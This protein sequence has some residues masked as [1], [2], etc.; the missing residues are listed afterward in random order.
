[1]DLAA[2]NSREPTRLDDR[3]APV[4]SFP[5][6]ELSIIVPTFN[7]HDNVAELLRRLRLC[8]PHGSW[9]VIFVD[10][11]S[12]DGT[13]ERVR[14]LAAEDSRVRCIQRVGRRGLASA[15]VEGMLSTSA[16]YLAVIDADLQHD[17]RLLPRMLEALRQEE[18][19]IV[20]GSR[21]AAGGDL[22]DWDA[23]RARLSRLATRLSRTL[24]PA[25][26][27]DP[28][29]GF[30]MIRREAFMDS[31]R[32]LSSI[33]FKILADLFA[34]S[35]RALRF[36]E[37]GYIFGTRQAGESKFDSASA[38]DY[39]MLVLD[40]LVGRWLPVRFIAFSLVG[41]LGVVVHFAVL[42]VAFQVLR[43]SFV[44]SQAIAIGCAM[45]FNFAVNNLLTYRDRRLRG[46]RWL[47]GWLTFML[48]CSLGALMNLGLAASLYRADHA[49]PL[50]ALCGILVGAIWNYV[51]TTLTTWGRPRG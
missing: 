45:T 9:E 35:P 32:H 8:L 16:A 33:G 31:Q 24:V 15:C 43:S 22:G 49:W 26:L 2:S 25:Q 38:W 4:P 29:S 46:L 48:A 42:S 41:A 20:V 28:M 12:P 6:P 3:R 11:D 39:A 23:R 13:A 1:M 34:S 5:G 19:D 51:A 14:A 50:A 30:F 18:I 21:Y 47:R 27:T 17:E 40:K 7:E 44:A 36:R 37:L 10:D